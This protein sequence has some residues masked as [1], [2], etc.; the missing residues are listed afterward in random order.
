MRQILNPT[1]ELATA[2][3]MALLGLSFISSACAQNPF[4]D[5]P[6]NSSATEP[7]VPFGEPLPDAATDLALSPGLSETSSTTANEADPVVRLLR[8]S[9]PKSAE[10]WADALTWMARIKR[11]DEVRR[12]LDDLT[13]ANWTIENKAALAR[14]GGSALWIRLRAD[15]AALTDPQS[16]LVRDILLAPGKLARDA[17]AIDNSIDQLASQQPGERKL[18]QYRL[19]DGSTI[20]IQ[21]LVDR[22]L[23]GDPKVSPAMLA[24]TIVSFGRDGE[25]AL[26]AACIVR[27]PQRAGRALLA[28]AQLPKGAFTAELGAGL[29][30]RYLPMEVQTQL[31]QILS[32]KY[33]TIPDT[34]SVHSYLKNRFDAA[35][36][37]YQLQRA[38]SG[39]LSTLVWRPTS[40]GQ[41]IQL[42]EVPSALKALERMGQLAFHVAN[43]PNATREDFVST[44]ACLL[45][46][47]YQINPTLEVGELETQLPSA[48]DS[49]LVADANY[50]QQLFAQADEWEMHGA[51]LRSIQLLTEHSKRGEFLAPLGFLS[52]LLRDSRPLIRYS[53]LQSIAQINPQQPFPGAEKSIEVA[54]EMTSLGSGPHALV[55]G[56]QSEMRQAATQLLSLRSGGKVTEANTG[57]AALLELDGSEP[58]ELILLVDRVSDVSVFEV[59]QR[60]RN[61]KK[62]QSLPIAVLTERLY[63]HERRQIGEMPGVVLS[64]LS[65]DPAQ[66]DRVLQSMLSQLD[67]NPMSAADRGVF[68]QVGGDFLATIADDRD[69]YAFYP[70]S[71]WR[72]KLISAQGG[73]PLTAH[74]SVIA[75]VGSADGQLKLSNMA[76]TANFSEQERLAAA[77]AF[78]K[79]VKRFGMLMQADDILR[80]YDLYN[81]LGPHDPA[82]IKALGLILDVTEAHA[83]KAAWPEGL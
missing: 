30:S 12:L 81:E 77:K 31:T 71:D 68:S 32:T 44:G 74:M 48:F 15:E 9:P 7:F 58:I 17:E 51:A 61:T 39:A 56:M 22:L 46:R 24:S 78:G 20:A 53:A 45:Q 16:A 40:D 1:V 80:N 65:R 42:V 43:L 18:A 36:T 21:R 54:L 59:L 75:A 55:V 34:K 4:G 62:G 60:F 73:L 52:D 10:Q 82:A 49:A 83:G 79:S 5:D 37:D 69:L 38:N 3:A 35:L 28:L 19:H 47:A 2:L 26:R 6:F 25:E 41:T 72:E 50:W 14:A 70:I 64:V 11:W 23:N 13:A 57:K 66:M 67:T 27:D 33:G 29:A 63:Q 76:A 8:A